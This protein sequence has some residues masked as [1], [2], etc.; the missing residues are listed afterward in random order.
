MAFFAAL[1]FLTVLP[2]FVRRQFTANELGRAVGY[3]P[4][5]GLFIGGLLWGANELMRDLWPPGIRATL[6]LA[7]WTLATGALHLDGFLDA[8]DGV[9]GANTPERR[10]EIMRDEHVG[11]FAV[12]GGALLISTKFAALT[13]LPDT[14]AP[15]LLAPALGRCGMTLAIVFFPYARKEGLGRTMKDYAGWLEVLVATLTVVVAC[16]WAGQTRAMLAMAA[17]AGTTL[18]IAWFALRRLGGLTGDI[19]GAVC[20]LTEVAILLYFAANF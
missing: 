8:C 2:P 7:L 16:W 14:L 6:T 20:E 10:L 9:F 3:F 11:A 15:Y 12:I 4:L 5:V 17:A 19:Y 18:C 1:Q 13:A